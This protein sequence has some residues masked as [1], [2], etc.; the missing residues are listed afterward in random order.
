[1]APNKKK[2]TDDELASRHGMTGE[3]GRHAKS[4]VS[5]ARGRGKRPTGTA[6][7]DTKLTAWGDVEGQEQLFACEPD[8]AAS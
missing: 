5:A 3:Q 8:G 7:A 4:Q 2:P 1:M 6:G